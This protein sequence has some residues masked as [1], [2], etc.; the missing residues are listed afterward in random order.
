MQ[1]VLIQSVTISILP[2]FLL[3]LIAPEVMMRLPTARQ[4]HAPQLSHLQVVVVP[5]MP[6]RMMSSRH[7]IVG[8]AAEG[9][10]HTKR[11]KI[12]CEFKQVTKVGRI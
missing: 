7:V 11:E 6:L 4:L 3:Y 8:Q 2:P 10:K 9:E 12:I 5:L 1:D